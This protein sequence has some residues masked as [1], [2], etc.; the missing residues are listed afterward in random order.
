[1][2]VSVVRGG[3]VEARHR[4]H[5]V[6]VRGGDV[7]AARG[8][9]SLVTYFRSSAKPMQALLL[10]RARPDLADTEVAI[11]CASHR[12]EPAQL[13]AV[14]SL[15]TKAP[16]TE[17]DLECGE[18]EGR[19][20]GRIHH[21]C[22]GKHAS[23]LA[24]C[25]ARGW[26]TAGYRLAHHPLQQ[27]L[28]A[29]VAAAAQLP[30]AEIPTA[31]DGCGVVTFALS[32]ERMAAS[33]AAFAQ[34]DGADR[35]LEAIR[36]HPELVGG[37]GSLDTDLMRARPGWIA[38]GGAEGLLCAVSPDGSGY[39]LKCEDGNPRALRPALAR[40]LDIDLGTVPVESSRGEIVGEVVVE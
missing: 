27:E 3:T 19:P 20:S 39:V 15:L 18:Q 26:E 2:S 24:V 30:V 13:A 33:F 38:K 35:I 6:V 36:S 5:A 12:A 22:S 40:F 10:V 23:F 29:E 28:L 25:R 4:V 1:M 11:A 32:L 31:V 7:V 8:D 9:P 14:R 16:A 21:N 34:R 37:E 17:E